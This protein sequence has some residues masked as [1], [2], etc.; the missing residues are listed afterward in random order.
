VGGVV[1]VVDQVVKRARMLGVPREHPGQDRRHLLLRPAPDERVLV[2][3]VTAL[4][5]ERGAPRRRPHEG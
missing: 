4:A 2:C 3:V 5:E 1:V